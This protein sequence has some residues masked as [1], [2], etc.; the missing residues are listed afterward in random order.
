M[1]EILDNLDRDEFPAGAGESFGDSR[2]VDAFTDERE[3][4]VE[5]ALSAAVQ[6]LAQW[7]AA[8]LAQ[9]YAR[10]FALV[11]TF[12]DTG[13]SFSF[14]DSASINGRS[15]PVMGTVDDAVFDHPKTSD[16]DLYRRQLREFVLR[17][18]MRV[19]DFRR[20]TAYIEE[21]RSHSTSAP[22]GLSWCPDPSVQHEGFGYS[23]WR[24][25]LR[26]T[27]SIGEFPE[28]QRF[29]IVDLREIGSQY[30][31]IVVRVKI[32][33][34]TVGLRLFGEET[35]Q[36]QIPLEEESYLV[37]SS[38]FIIDDSQTVIEPDGRRVVGRYGFGYAFLKDPPGRLLAYG[39]GEFDAAFQQ[40]HFRVYEDGEIRTQLVFVANRP[41][42]I[43]RVPFAPVDWPIRL[44]NAATFGVGSALLNPISD[45]MGRLT[46]RLGSFDPVGAYI[47]LANALTAGQAAD[48]L[49]ISREELEKAFLIQH[50]RQHY[51]MMTGALQTW[52][53]IA[54]WTDE[55]SLPEWVRTGV[56]S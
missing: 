17:Y 24:F 9:S 42:Q 5:R 6:L 41:N 35:P 11:R 10:R 1:A 14:F 32:F 39:P 27:E 37:L 25:K 22:G 44:A 13:T 51:D 46:E 54:D 20:P 28:N 30:E 53:R 31:W 15:V 45:A 21:G 18:M 38:D 55:G 7:R 19:T 12:N 48:R 47:D 40:I 29:E 8:D 36:L 33:N 16:M 50:F 56:S 4:D 2:S 34:F 23:Q 49:C 52:R 3:G 26:G 43:A